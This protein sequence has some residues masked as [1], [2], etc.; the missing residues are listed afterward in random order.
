MGRLRT[1]IKDLDAKLDEQGAM[2]CKGKPIDRV[3]EYRE[4]KQDLL[5]NVDLMLDLRNEGTQRQLSRSVA[6]R[7]EFL[8]ELEASWG[9]KCFHVKTL[10]NTG[11]VNQG[12]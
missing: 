2:L 1:L 9:C 11:T 5:L 7:E 3:I 10:L 12:N 4:N 6:E 8:A